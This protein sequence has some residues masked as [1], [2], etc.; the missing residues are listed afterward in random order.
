MTTAEVDKVLGADEN[1][2]LDALALVL[3]TDAMVDGAA[4]GALDAAPAAVK[5]INWP[6]LMATFSRSACSASKVD[7]L[8]G[9]FEVAAEVEAE[10]GDTSSVRLALA[11]AVEVEVDPLSIPLEID[12][13]EDAKVKLDEDSLPDP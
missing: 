10:V 2:V 9:P 3:D 7:R 5:G 8:T 13:V 6:R 1:L 12:V 4:D 11:N